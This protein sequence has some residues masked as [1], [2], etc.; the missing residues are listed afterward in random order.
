[1]P[2]AS[3]IPLRTQPDPEPDDRTTIDVPRPMPPAPFVPIG[4]GEPMTLPRGGKDRPH[5]ERTIAAV[6]KLIEETTLTYHQIA[7]PA[8]SRR[9]TDGSSSPG[10]GWASRRHARYALLSGTTSNPDVRNRWH[11]MGV[12]DVGITYGAGSHCCHRRMI[13]CRATG[14]S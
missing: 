10:R 9:H 7:A 4:L 1:M 3:I 5:A 12:P 6:R 13:V 8:P 11:P 14:V 2:S